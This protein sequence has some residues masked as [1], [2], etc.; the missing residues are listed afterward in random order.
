MKISQQNVDNVQELLDIALEEA[1]NLTES[2]IGYIYHYNEQ[3]EEFTL[4]TW[5]RDVMKECTIANPQSLY[6]LEKTG[7][8]GEAVR[9]RKASF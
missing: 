9:Q 3:K 1:I 4:N 7:I 8:W 2:K 5:S 6:P